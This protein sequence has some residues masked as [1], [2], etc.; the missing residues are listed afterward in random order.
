MTRHK[1]PASALRR[2]AQVR[3]QEKDRAFLE[4]DPSGL[5]VLHDVEEGVAL[6][7]VEE[8]LVGIVVEIGAAVGTADD[9]DDEIAHLRFGRP[10]LR[11][12]DRGLEQMPVLLD[13]FGE[14]E[15]VHRGA[16]SLMQIFVGSE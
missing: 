1:L 8:F 11:V 14:V 9:G 7:L 10:D 13:P 4:I 15:G 6:H 3:R 16:Y 5:A 12:A 2:V